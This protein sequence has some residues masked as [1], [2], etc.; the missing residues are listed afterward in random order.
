MASERNEEAGTTENKKEVSKEFHGIIHFSNAEMN[1]PKPEL[2][3]LAKR[4]M[5]TLRELV[6]KRIS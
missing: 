3:E 6:E 4:K 2:W 1:L 5:K